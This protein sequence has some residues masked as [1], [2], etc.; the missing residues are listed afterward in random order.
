MLELL[1][2]ENIAVIEKA[3]IEFSPGFNVLTGE[4]GAGKSIVIDSLSAVLGL[5]I[6]KDIV[7]TGESRG[8]VTATFTDVDVAAWCEDNGI[9]FDGELILMRRISA[10]GKNQCRI[11]GC[12]V[13]V[14]QLKELGGMLLDI[15]GQNDG[16]RLLDEGSHRQYLDGFGGLERDTADYRKNYDAYVDVKQQLEALSMDEG[17]KERRADILKFQI[18]ELERAN[19]RIGEMEE[20]TARRDLL[21]NSVKL[22]DA[23]ERA[24]EAMYGGDDFTGA[25]SLISD[26]A[27]ELQ[28]AARY[29]DAMSNLASRLEELRY[30]AE[31]IAEELR[32]FRESLDFS[33]EELDELENRLD[34]LKKL[35]RKYGDT[36]EEMLDYLGRSQE[37]LDNIEYFAE[38]TEQLTAELIKRRAAAEVSAEKLSAK[39]KT[40]AKKLEKRIMEELQS[41]NMPGVKFS[42]EFLPIAQEPGFNATG[43]DQVRFI[44]SANAGQ[45]M[46]RIS[47]IASGGELSRIM[48][49]MKS[50][51]AENDSIGS[52]VFDEIDTGVSGIAAQRVGEKMWQL[53][54]GKQVICVTHLPQIAAMAD[55]HFEISKSTDHGET[56]TAVTKLDGDGRTR[57]IA[58]LTGGD[59]ITETTLKSAAEQI[60][61]AEQFKKAK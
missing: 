10:D 49:A 60:S 12:P 38:K 52:M 26:A 2:I 44:M 14:A 23:V 46:G 6:S 31:D 58:R 54:E 47:K 40:A 22:T 1:H 34:Q 29:T 13:S 19:I 56:F 32:D 18:E 9:D 36:E 45:S 43:A 27:G 20:K 35:S 25:A 3:D 11:N 4:T 30:S 55:S 59:R 61:A 17:E 24:Y 53:S 50:V 33:P 37:E 7:R 5:R 8:T 15:H 16:Q 39:R 41:L 21:R 28:S 51:L 42:V 48:L 57:E